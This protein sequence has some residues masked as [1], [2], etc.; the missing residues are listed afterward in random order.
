MKKLAIGAVAAIVMATSFATAADA[1]WRWRHHGG[2]HHRAH[3]GV[4]IGPRV[5][6]GPRV[7]IGSGCVVKK[8]I[9]RYGEVVRKRWC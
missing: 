1:G 3:W 5:W 6:I 7:V 9:N 2:W 8:K 4:V